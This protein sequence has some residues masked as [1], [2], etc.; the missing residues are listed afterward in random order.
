MT[1]R[2]LPPHI[3]LPSGMWRFVKRGGSTSQGKKR[4]SR[5]VAKRKSKRSGG[6]FG[7][8]GLN[9]LLTV[10]NVMLTVAGA[11]LLPK[12]VPQV[13]PNIGGAIGGYMGS[14][15]I[16]G[17]VVGYLVAPALN[18]ITSK[19]LGGAGVNMGAYTY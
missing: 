18:D 3:V 5:N 15:S 9:K 14:K 10:K 17:A 19:M 1:K 2:K 13:S 4:R 16:V 7:G 6:G 12:V 11:A 8:F